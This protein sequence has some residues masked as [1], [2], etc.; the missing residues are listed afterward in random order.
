MKYGNLFLA[1]GTVSLSLSLFS[2]SISANEKE[3]IKFVFSP[4]E[5]ISFIQKLSVKKEKDMGDEGKQLDESISTTKITIT[6]TKDGWDVLAKPIDVSM[7]R[8]GKEVNDP[9]A[10]LL[11]SAVITYKLDTFGNILD[12]EGYERF[13][14]RISKQLPPDIFQQLAPV[15]NIDAIKTKEIAEWNG[16]IGDYIGAEVKI[17]DRFSAEVPFQLPNGSTI[18]Y[19]VNTSIAAMEP[20]AKSQ[21]VRIEQVY[22]SQTDELAKLSGNVL[23]NVTKAIAPEIEKG[24]PES[25]TSTISGNVKRTI[26]PKTMLLY[27]EELTRV[28]S[29]KMDVPGTGSSSLKVIETRVYEFLY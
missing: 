25:N 1:L 21:C 16:R 9:I 14:D 23:S 22:D 28:I 10:T 8:N 27:G 11:L 12:V 17:G 5:K 13:I 26:D 15:L 19:N 29:M 3:T 2:A 4:G 20:C 18:N 6:R 7:T 24:K